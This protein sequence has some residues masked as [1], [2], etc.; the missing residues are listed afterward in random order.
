MLN[1][2]V[3]TIPGTHFLQIILY[4]SKLYNKA[5]NQLIIAETIRLM[6]CT[7]DFTVLEA[8]SH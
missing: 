1:S 6:K 3:E 4:G 8:F 7:G 5:V 2:N